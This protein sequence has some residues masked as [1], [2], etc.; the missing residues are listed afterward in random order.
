M[1]MLRSDRESQENLGEGMHQFQTYAKCKGN[2]TAVSERPGP[3]MIAGPFVY[4]GEY[5]AGGQ[6]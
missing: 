6:R 2:R 5:A 4:Q 1:T 3:V